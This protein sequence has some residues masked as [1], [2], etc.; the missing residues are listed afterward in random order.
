MKLQQAV[1]TIARTIFPITVLC[2]QGNRQF[3]VPI[4]EQQRVPFFLPPFAKDNTAFI[5]TFANT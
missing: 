3:S 2:P 5:M 1:N 4:K